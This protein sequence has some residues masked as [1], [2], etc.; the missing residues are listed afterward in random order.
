MTTCVLE[1]GRAVARI[2]NVK[3]RIEKTEDRKNRWK[4]EKK[5][6]KIGGNRGF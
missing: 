1:L 2:D 4:K 3:G 6:L 5:S